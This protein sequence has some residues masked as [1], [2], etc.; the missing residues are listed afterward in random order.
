MTWEE[1]KKIILTNEWLVIEAIEAHTEGN[2]RV[3]EQR[4]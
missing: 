2:R 1:V 4:I 3:I